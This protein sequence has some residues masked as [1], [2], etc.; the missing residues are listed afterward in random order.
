MLGEVYKYDRGVCKGEW[1]ARSSEPDASDNGLHA[2]PASVSAACREQ[3]VQDGDA[4]ADADEVSVRLLV[5]ADP[6]AGRG[7]CPGADGK[8]GGLVLAEVMVP[9]RLARHGP[10]N[11]SS[12]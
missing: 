10:F 7:I 9:I 2:L 4:D 8:M 6:I 11:L 1:N 12:S 5:E 3:W